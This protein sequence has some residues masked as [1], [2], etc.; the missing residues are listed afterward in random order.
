MQTCQRVAE[1]LQK[2]NK[3]AEKKGEV[4]MEKKVEKEEIKLTV[5][6]QSQM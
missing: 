2:G 5:P 3:V 6:L 4:S 1:A